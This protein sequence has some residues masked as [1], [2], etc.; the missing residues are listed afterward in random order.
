MVNVCEPRVDRVGL[1]IGAAGLAWCERN[2]SGC[3]GS[4]VAVGGRPGVG[5]IFDFHIRGIKDRVVRPGSDQVQGHTAK[6]QGLER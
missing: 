5:F 1:D 2:V 3:E 4:A 6:D